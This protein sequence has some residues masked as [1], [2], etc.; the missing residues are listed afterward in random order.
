MHQ[1][2]ASSSPHKWPTPSQRIQDL[3][4]KGAEFV[5]NIPAEW[6]QEL[7]QASLAADLVTADPVLVA[8]A[9]RVNRSGMIH[10]AA[11]NIENPGA[12]V[13]RFISAD[14]LTNARELS[15]RGV[16]DLMFNAARS[17]QNA[18]WQRW[19]HIAFSLTSDPE[20][21]QELLDISAR[22]IAAFI[23]VN[24]EGINEIMRTEREERMQGT[25]ADRRE[26]VTLIIE[27]TPISVQQ[28]NRRLGYTLEQAHHAAVIWSEDADTELGKLEQAAEALAK[29]SATRQSLVVMVNA[30]TLWVWVHG[31][32]DIDLQALQRMVK[33]LPGVHIALASAGSGIDGFRRGHLDAIATQRLLGRLQASAGV[34]HADEMRLVTLMTQHME[35][36]HQFITHTLGDLASADVALRQALFTFLLAGCNATEAARKVFTHRNTLLR[37]LERAEDLLPRPLHENRLDVAAALEILKWIND[38][39]S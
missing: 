36:A 15:R 21:L 6:L 16:S 29:C 1:K 22:S 30:A 7:D 20:E 13:P 5:L 39:H 4:R 18:A 9:K 25:H 3:M 19:M 35:S 31:N 27:G 37:R 8:A 33:T 24:M 34:V 14:M 17:S 23:D 26:L 10:W 12:P 38:E 28:A 2:L 11:A 32:K